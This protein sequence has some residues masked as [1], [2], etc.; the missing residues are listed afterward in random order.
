M[1]K[2]MGLTMLFPSRVAV[3]ALANGVARLGEAGFQ[4]FHDPDSL[5]T[6]SLEKS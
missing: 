6:G 1:V 5:F 3:D 4:F 2:L